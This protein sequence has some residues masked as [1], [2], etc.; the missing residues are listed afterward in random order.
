MKYVRR[1]LKYQQK[2]SQGSIRNYM[3]W[4]ERKLSKVNLKVFKKQAFT[5]IIIEDPVAGK[6]SIQIAS[7]LVGSI[8]VAG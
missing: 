4:N 7:I 2:V 3:E 8:Q 6:I 5:I 1:K